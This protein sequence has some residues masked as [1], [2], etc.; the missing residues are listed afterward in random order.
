MEIK[1]DIDDLYDFDA[2][3]GAV[4]TRQKILDAG[5]GTEFMAALEDI[6]PDG[7]TE[8]ELNDLLWFEPEQCYEMVGLDENGDEPEEDEEDEEDEESEN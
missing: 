4:D 7:M 5:K 8:T 2:W 6:Y 3:S 1:K